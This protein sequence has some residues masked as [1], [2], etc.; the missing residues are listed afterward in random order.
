MGGSVADFYFFLIFLYIYAVH[1]KT[2][3]ETNN[4]EV[5]HVKRVNTKKQELSPV[6]S[7]HKNQH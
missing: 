7:G 6:L 1:G 4:K 3:L 5:S 2:K